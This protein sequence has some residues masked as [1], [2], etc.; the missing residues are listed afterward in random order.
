MR[1]ALVGLLAGAVGIAFAPI[2]YKLV[3]A[4]SDLGPISIAF[5]RILLALPLLGG[6]MAIERGKGGAEPPTAPPAAGPPPPRWQLLLPGLFFAGDLSMWHWSLELTSA[7]NATLLV[8]CAPIPVAIVGWLWLKERFGATFIV[9]FLLA[10]AGVIVV[11][12]SSQDNQ[13][14]SLTGD[15]LGLATALFYGG[16][17]LSVKRLRGHY[18]VPVIMMWVACVS[19]PVLLVNSLIGG[20]TMLTASWAAW[21]FLA[22]MAIVSHVVGQGL[23]VW[24]LRHLPVS[25]SSVSLLV[26]PVAVALL[27]WPILHEPVRA[28]QAVGGVIVLAG[29]FLARRGSITAKQPQRRVGL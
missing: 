20:E 4:A 8:N 19:L 7:A 23:I 16:Y 10:M 18:P 21:G 27:A 24:A 2:F 1:L 25:F 22:A 9:G 13:S 5:W 26:Q 15:A 29:V 17:Q 28:L 11:M 3:D 12:K 6:W 14:A